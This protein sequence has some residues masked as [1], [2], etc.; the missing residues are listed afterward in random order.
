MK[1]VLLH[2][3]R[4]SHFLCAVFPLVISAALDCG[5]SARVLRISITIVLR[6]LY[7]IALYCIV[8]KFIAWH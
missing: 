3:E 1:R 7:C 4:W 8:L 5:F 6:V 2:I